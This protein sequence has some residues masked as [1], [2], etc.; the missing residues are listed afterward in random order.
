MVDWI[1]KLAV[2]VLGVWGATWLAQDYLVFLPRFARAPV[3]MP[4]RAQPIE[5]VTADGV[6]LRGWWIPPRTPVDA[7]GK[8]PVVIYFGGN[9]DNVSWTLADARWP[10]D[11]ALAGFNYRGY[12]ESEGSPGE[13]A[14]IADALAIRDL[15]GGR[16]DVDSERIVAFGRSLG[17]GVAVA[18]AAA[19]PLG[20]VLLASPFDSLVAVGRRHYPYLPVS[21]LLRHRFDSAA[22]APRLSVPM[23]AIVAQDDT[24]IP[25]ERSRSLYDAWAGAKSWQVVEHADHNTLSEPAE[26]WAGVAGFLERVASRAR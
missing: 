16:E 7:G 24:I 3:A 5:L 23:H 26:Y 11:W 15:I 18:L 17:S 4:E 13:R 12:G 8:A 2:F 22:L 21:L 25:P 19:R 20:G 6:R 1:V 10:G 9:A 14:L